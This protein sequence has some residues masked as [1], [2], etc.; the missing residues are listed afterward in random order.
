M[1]RT[2]QRWTFIVALAAGVMSNW[3]PAAAADSRVALVI[4]NGNYPTAPL[5]NPS[6]DANAVAAMLKSLGFDV[7]LRTHSTRREMTRV[8]SEF[9]RKVVPGVVALFYYAGH[10]MQVKGKNYLIPVDAEIDS[11]DMVATEGIE[12]GVL[13]DT[14]KASRLNVVILDAC[15][16]NPF[17]RNSRSGSGLAE[18]DAPVG[19]FLAYA[20]AP[21][22]VAA[23]GTGNNGLYTSELL[24]ALEM[25]GLKI[26]DV[27]K[28]VRI[29]VLKASGNTQVPWE[30]SSMTREFY[31][32]PDA[33]AAAV[34]VQL[35]RAE[36]ERL[37]LQREMEKLRVELNRLIGSSK[38]ATVPVATTAL[39]SPPQ[40]AAPEMPAAT[41][42]T[43]PD[44]ATAITTTP[45][46]T[47]A[48]A[49]VRFED[50]WT[51]RINLLKELK[52]R[53][54]YAEAVAILFDIKQ[55]DELTDVVRFDR[56]LKGT[57]WASALA[58]GVNR[59]GLPLWANASMYRA[60]SFAQESALDFCGKV[61]TGKDSSGKDTPADA[62]CE[63]VIINGDLQESA[64]LSIANKLKNVDPGN[65]R[66]AFLASISAPMAERLT[67]GGH[68]A[69]VVPQTR[70]ARVFVPDI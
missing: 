40:S 12:A 53:M 18:I 20:T 7:T 62:R 61:Q 57:S 69:G 49:N 67:P 3:N 5:R 50:I 52:G 22:K 9:Q 24:K 10:G 55:D 44:P 42:G 8:I 14:L 28:Q 32:R 15:R 35:R 17:A 23:D 66:K 38:V 6:N 30:S 27:F 45:S 34:D 47:T 4:G 26:E 48:A 58:M 16:D 59:Q 41:S 13:L 39:A 54:S 60:A 70:A 64:L 33:K 63:L 21:G 37:E 31:F 11:E 56:F 29:N 2:A 46:S 68:G 25:P 36:A 43:A 51:N 19:T 1:I 65:A